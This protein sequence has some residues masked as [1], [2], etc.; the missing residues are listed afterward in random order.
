MTQL[1]E[2]Y[3]Q[4]QIQNRSEQQ[5]ENRLLYGFYPDVIKQNRKV[6]FYDNGIRNMIIGNFNQ[7]DLRLDKRALWENFLVSERRKQNFYKNTFSKMYFW[8]TK[9]QQEIDFVEENSGNIS[10]FEFKWINKKTKFPQKFMEAYK[11]KGIVID[12]T[13]FSDVVI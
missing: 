11:A 13:N 1:Q 4:I 2:A 9:Q 8:R 3:Y 5:L 12:R 6:Y 10:G 7:L